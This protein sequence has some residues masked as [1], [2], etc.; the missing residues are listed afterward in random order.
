[1]WA[2]DAV[3]TQKTHKQLMLLE[4]QYHRIVNTKKQQPVYVARLWKEIDD[5]L[6]RIWTAL[7]A[8]VER[9]A[10]PVLGLL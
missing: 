3:G 7:T 4:G 6:S 10:G 9:A 8:D 2:I 5:L 1:M